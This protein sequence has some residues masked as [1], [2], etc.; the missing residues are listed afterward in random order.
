MEINEY[1][2]DENFF[3]NPVELSDFWKLK[4][5]RSKSHSIVHCYS[6]DR[7]L[8]ELSYNTIKFWVFERARSI[9]E[10]AKRFGGLFEDYSTYLQENNHEIHGTEFISAAR[11]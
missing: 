5:I 1:R 2:G 11:K 10:V 6:K 9:N 4:K 8:F 3:R 7:I